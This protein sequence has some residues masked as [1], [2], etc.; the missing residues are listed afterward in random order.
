[1]PWLG[2]QSWVVISDLHFR[3]VLRTEHS[4]HGSTRLGLSSDLKSVSIQIQANM[5]QLYWSAVNQEVL[6][7]DVQL[8][9]GFICGR[10]AAQQ[11]TGA[12]P[13][14]PVAP[15]FPLSAC[16]KPLA[17]PETIKLKKFRY[18]ISQMNVVLDDM[19][20][21]DGWTHDGMSDAFGE[22]LIS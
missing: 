12:A 4:N 7:F 10:G 19:H 16:M 22:I 13:R 15:H 9:P 20:M 17:D 14:R 2:G 11:H 21:A 5:R 6:G 8:G 18:R 1:M 3:F